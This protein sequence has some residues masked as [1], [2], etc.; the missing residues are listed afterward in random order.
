MHTSE[1]TLA[2]VGRI[3]KMMHDLV[4]QLHSDMQVM[5]DPQAKA[6]FSAAEETI[7]RAIKAIRDFEQKQFSG[8]SDKRFK[9]T[10]LSGV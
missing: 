9:R 6:I 2:S 1:R 3:R 10:P 5:T 4:G 8:S 7:R